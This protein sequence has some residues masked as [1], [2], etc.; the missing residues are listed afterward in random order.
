MRQA[1]GKEQDGKKHVKKKINTDI[2]FFAAASAVAEKKVFLSE[3]A[4][5]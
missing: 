5:G 4:N 3:N 2:S 1:L